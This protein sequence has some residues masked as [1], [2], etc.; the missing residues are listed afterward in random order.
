MVV[1]AV[2][3]GVVAVLG[4]VQHTGGGQMENGKE[5]VGC[6]LVCWGVLAGCKVHHVQGKT[7]INRCKGGT[8]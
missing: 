2:W 3:C 6:G 1:A 8:Q 5:G 4:S 7:E